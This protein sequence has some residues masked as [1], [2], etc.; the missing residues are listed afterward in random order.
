MNI[1]DVLGNER[2]QKFLDDRY[3]GESFKIRVPD[4]VY[5]NLKS[6]SRMVIVDHVMM[7]IISHLWLANGGPD[8]L[9]KEITEPP[10]G[11]FPDY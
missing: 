6:K 5:D 9:P 10:F 3:I 1:R 4:G 8:D 11:S 7:I 2:V